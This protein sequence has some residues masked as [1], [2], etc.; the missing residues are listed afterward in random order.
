MS[1][2]TGWLASAAEA[3]RPGWDR[4]GSVRWL[5]GA[6]PVAVTAGILVALGIAQLLPE[7]GAG[8][9]FRLASAGA[10]VLLL[11]GG[12][13]LRVVGW[14]ENLGAALA[15][16]FALSLAVVFACMAF[17]FVV[18]GSI[19]DGAVALGVVVLAALVPAALTRSAEER[20][21]EDRRP[22]LWVLLGSLPL[23]ALVWWAAGPIQGDGLF[24]LARVR[25]LQEFETLTNVGVVNQFQDGSIHSGY[26]FPLWHGALALVGQLAGVDAAQVF[27]YLPALLAPLLLIVLYGAGSTLFGHWAGGVAVVAVQVAA[28]FSRGGVQAGTGGFEHLAQAP[29]VGR[30]L[31]GAVVLALAFAFVAQ[32]RRGLLVPLAA[33]GF[34]LA[35]IH[36]TYNPYAVVVL[37]GFCVARLLLSGWADGSAKRIAVAAG[38]VLVPFGLFLVW[39]FPLARADPAQRPS[40]SLRNFEIQHYG[41]ALDVFGDLLRFSP[42]AIARGGPVAVVG[43]L[44]V[45]LAVFGARRQWGAFVLGATLAILPILLVPQLFTLL[46]DSFSTSQARRLAA[47]LPFVFAIAG[48]AIVA[49]RFRIAG[50]AAMGAVGL[51]TASLFPGEFTYKVNEGGPGWTVW[52]AAAG[53]VLAV[54]IGALTRLRGP[55]PDRWS[56]LAALAFLGAVA[57]F[58][59]PDIGESEEPPHLTPEV[60][61]AVRENTAPG[62]VVFSD[63][64]TSFTIAGYAPVYINAEPG[65]HAPFT[66]QNR[67]RARTRDSW[68]FLTAPNVRDAERRQ[69]LENYGADWVLVDKE[70]RHPQE[71]LDELRLVYGDDRFALYGVST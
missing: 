35:V 6:G 64:I 13:I 4:M 32:G 48:A 46:A 43:L 15:A 31:L 59:L 25:K 29:V 8:L 38:T 53:G 22:A 70:R 42:D 30:T 24:H 10:F 58:G 54:V 66:P 37:A 19:A 55:S 62:D 34:A 52:V 14:P 67:P 27:L 17:V 45:P 60:I 11:P 56:A 5:P 26:A 23:V 57:V 40:E 41:D 39:L 21:A 9:A 3:A 68:R 36:P 69:I 12:L 50:V 1:P 51:L 33:A 20:G 65:G 2:S 61:E 18:G 16:S 44:A 71:F 49:G 7:T 28:V 47:F 63:I